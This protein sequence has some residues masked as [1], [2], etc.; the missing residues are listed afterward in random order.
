[1]AREEADLQVVLAPTALIAFLTGEGPLEGEVV[2]VA[3]EAVGEVRTEDTEAEPPPTIKDPLKATWEVTLATSQG[4]RKNPSI[5]M[6]H[7]TRGCLISSSTDR[8][9]LRITTRK[10][11]GTM[12]VR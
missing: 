9:M 6:A 1:M 2:S 10:A 12:K 3:V 5:R 8:L 4:P 11:M 7:T